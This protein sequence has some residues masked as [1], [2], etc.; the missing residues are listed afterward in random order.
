MTRAA[1]GDA[2]GI[3]PSR[4]AFLPSPSLPLA[5]LAGAHASLAAA[6]A[7]LVVD[8]G[9]PGGFVY[10]PRALALVHLVTLGWISG[11]IL[12]ALYIVAPLAFGV[13]MRAGRLDAWA[14]ASFWGGTAG[15]V[16]GFWTGRYDV[17]ASA[18]PFVLAPIV[19]VGVR[20]GLG[21][22]R[23][24]LPAGIA[25]HVMLAFANVS[26][27]GV[28]GMLLALNRLTGTLS[29]SPVALAAAHAHLA[30]L[31]WATMMILGVAYRLIPMFVPA[32]MPS[33]PGLAAS[34]VLLEAGTLGVVVSLAVGHSPVPWLVFVVAALMAFFRVVRAIVRD[35]RPRPVDLPQ[36]DW[37]TWHTHLAMAYLCVAAVLGTVIAVAGSSP[38]LLWSYGATGLLGFVVQM[39][40]G[41]GGRLLPMYAWYRAV[42]RRGGV[43]PPISAHR[44]IVPQLSLAVLL[45]WLAGLPVF[46][47]GLM[48]GVSGLIAAGAAAMLAGT[49][50]NAVH[51]GAL[52][53]RAAGAALSDAGLT[54]PS[55]RPADPARP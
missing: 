39:V 2:S 50:L 41:I 26:A 17:L 38:A 43:P 42:E 53:R 16:S 37:S 52:A 48:R 28:V 10:H 21:L 30:L 3:S 23:S 51:M 11:S 13:P 33:G 40:V 27:A 7:V 8:P 6:L 47:V 46:T 45:C 55:P 31:G 22:R 35:K 4:R 12:G 19:V 49:V 44:L 24:R 29:W 5:Y 14:C 15:M 20:V 18:S 9:L 54:G 34:A 36:R 1:G 32:A 25:L